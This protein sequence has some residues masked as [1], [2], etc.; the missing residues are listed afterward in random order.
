MHLVPVLQPDQGCVAADDPP[1][2]RRGSIG[3]AKLDANTIHLLRKQVVPGV[4]AT[5]TW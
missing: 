3:R 5:L 2:T 4:E 1:C